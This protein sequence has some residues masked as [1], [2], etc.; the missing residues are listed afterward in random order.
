[1]KFNFLWLII[2]SCFLCALAE[3]KTVQRQFH[4]KWLKQRMTLQNLPWPALSG[5][6]ISQLILP[7]WPTILNSRQSSYTH[8]THNI[9]W[10]LLCWVTPRKTIRVSVDYMLT[11]WRYLIY[12]CNY[13]HKY[14]GSDWNGPS[15][16][17]VDEHFEYTLY[18]SLIPVI[19]SGQ[20]ILDH[21]QQLH[22]LSISSDA[23]L[24]RAMPR[25]NGITREIHRPLCDE[26][27]LTKANLPSDRLF[28]NVH[29]EFT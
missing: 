3:T 15:S 18:A 14:T 17:C 28:S 2:L 25:F 19:Q 5:V 12:K 29:K 8:C 13:N 21:H 22:L 1:V 27:S 20:N 16:G 23:R 26:W 6:V 9:C 11:S 24:N 7:P 4:A 10:V